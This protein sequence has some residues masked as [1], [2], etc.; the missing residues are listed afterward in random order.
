[1]INKN[2]LLSLLFLLS[3]SLAW[4][5]KEDDI[6]LKHIPSDAVSILTVHGR[7]IDL[8][9]NIK[10]LNENES[11][12]SSQEKI[13]NSLF[14]EANYNHDDYPTLLGNFENYGLDFI[15]NS[16][17]FMQ[18]EQDFYAVSY[19][20]NISDNSKFKTFSDGFFEKE[21]LSKLELPD[22]A[23]GFKMPF[24]DVNILWTETYGIITA[25]GPKRENKMFSAEEEENEEE[26]NI[27]YVI[28]NYLKKLVEL[29][30][31]ASIATNKTFDE[32]YEMNGD[33][34]IWFNNSL[35]SKI[36]NENVPA[37]AMFDPVYA[38]LD[39]LYAGTT[40]NISISL[41]NHG[42]SADIATIMN[43]KLLKH[44]KNF[45]KSGFSSD[46]IKFI[47]KDSL[48][49][50][51]GM[52]INMEAIE[53]YL[54]EVIY[55]MIQEIPMYG[56]RATDIMDI[57]GVVTDEEALYDLIEGDFVF[58]L[59]GKNT[60]THTITETDYDDDYNPI[61]VEKTV[62]ESY[63]KM[64]WIVSTK[65]D[66]TWDKF[67]GLYSMNHLLT[68]KD[69]YY[70][71]QN[72]W[73]KDGMKVFY[74]AKNGVI[75]VSTDEELITKYLKTGLPASK[76]AGGNVKTMFNSNNMVV[77]AQ[78]FDVI[79]DGESNEDYKKVYSAIEESNVEHFKFTGSTI[80]K[81][82]AES[83]LDLKFG[84]GE[85]N[86]INFIFKVINELSAEFV[87]EEV[88]IIEEDIEYDDYEY[89]EEAVPAEE[90]DD[91]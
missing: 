51:V 76:Q 14:G 59:N 71:Y 60:S 48:M 21:S 12:I 45:Q 5:Q 81:N 78:P 36:R 44:H 79:D 43:K 57:L 41:T 55:P 2:Q 32:N 40:T 49:L 26:F 13:L 25:Y 34:V 87:Q 65:D 27:H 56:E 16:Y 67:I 80:K 46:V 54:K 77:Y 29:D 1:M 86:A 4:S 39:E 37:L 63:P 85:L 42:L 50:A 53:P 61:E 15:A 28:N 30:T 18:I 72:R 35:Q 82:K 64:S 20:F 73:S 9:A 19:I 52:S 24:K 33:L 17:L 62:T 74:A 70:F 88:D 58:I 90:Y 47:P 22:G 7:R 3:F 68:K 69:D 31:K 84:D 75:I 10:K 6:L 8:K 91:Y 38:K 66:E 23:E 83:H 89:Y 11:F